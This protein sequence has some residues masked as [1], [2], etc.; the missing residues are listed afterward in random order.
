[1]WFLFICLGKLIQTTWS[2]SLS[3]RAKLLDND[4]ALSQHLPPYNYQKTNFNASE[5]V[6]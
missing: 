3:G 2:Q 4:K 5:D 1:M 6:Y